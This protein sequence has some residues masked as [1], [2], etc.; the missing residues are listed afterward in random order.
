MSASPRRYRYHTVAEAFDQIC[1][2][3][4]PWVAIGNFLNDWWFFTFEHRCEMIDTAVSPAPT[5]ELHRWAAFCAAMVE[6]L[7]WEE[8]IPCPA[9]TDQEC[10][11]LPEPW[12]FYEDW[13]SRAW[14]MA[15]TPAPFKMRN[16]YGGDRMFLHVPGRDPSTHDPTLSEALWGKMKE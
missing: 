9:W 7:C 5:P 4:A 10:Y 13:G 1:A 11:I 8:D 14:L 3:Q 2:G 15:T 6:H 12:F 16:I